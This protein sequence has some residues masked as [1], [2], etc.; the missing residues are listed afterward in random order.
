M[1][2]QVNTPSI[3]AYTYDG[4]NTLING[5]SKKSV[6]FL[7]ITGTRTKTKINNMDWQNFLIGIGSLLLAYIMFRGIK[8]EKPSS[9]YNNWTGPTQ[10]TYFGYWSVIIM[11][12]LIGV[13]FVLKSLPSQI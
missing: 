12:I 3:F 13:V 8:G 11:S 2:N 9:K 10:K 1:G 7:I 5:T 6:R 4:L